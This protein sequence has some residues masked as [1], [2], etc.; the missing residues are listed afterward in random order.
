MHMGVSHFV[1]V[2]TGDINTFNA[3]S[4][5][6][7]VN[8]RRSLQKVFQYCKENRAHLCVCVD[9]VGS[10]VGL[11]TT[12]VIPSYPHTLIPSYPYTLIPS[13]PHTLIPSYPHT[14]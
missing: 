4:R 9:D 6:H 8:R 10:V 5:L 14:L 13:Y 1:A 7:K 12:E 3:T 11:L 2:A